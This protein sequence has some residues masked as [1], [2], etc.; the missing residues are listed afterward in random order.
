MS[1]LQNFQQMKVVVRGMPEAQVSLSPLAKR[2]E[3]CGRLP[4]ASIQ[5]ASPQIYQ[6]RYPE[7]AVATRE[8][9]QLPSSRDKTA[10]SGKSSKVH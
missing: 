1:F 10:V 4:P 2:Q 3:G 9:A 7:V 6:S 8:E 5:D